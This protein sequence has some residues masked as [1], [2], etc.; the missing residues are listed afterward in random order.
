MRMDWAKE[1]RR[2]LYDYQKAKRNP[3]FH[4]S[5]VKPDLDVLAFEIATKLSDKHVFGDILPE[6]VI[7]RD[8]L[9]PEVRKYLVRRLKTQA[10]YQRR[11]A[12]LERQRSERL[13]QMIAQLAELRAAFQVACPS[14]K[15]VTSA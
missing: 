1:M 6:V 4:P 9:H 3:Q 11:R 12:E 15:S 14:T 5:P 10:E 13:D 2:R 7:H 8:S